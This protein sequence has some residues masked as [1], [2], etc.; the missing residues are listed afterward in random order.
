[1]CH[2]STQVGLRDV[3]CWEPCLVELEAKVSSARRDCATLFYCM[4]L[5]TQDV[6]LDARHLLGVRRV[7]TWWVIV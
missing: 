6:S 3:E 4:S 5:G 2:G 7:V 1:M